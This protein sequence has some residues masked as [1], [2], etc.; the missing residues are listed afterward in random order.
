MQLVTSFKM[1]FQTK[2]FNEGQRVWIICGTGS[3]AALCMGKFR[4]KGKYVRAWV[5]WANKVCPVPQEFEV[6]EVFAKKI[7]GY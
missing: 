2:H 1:P 7:R 3:Q 4:G 5:K 6:D